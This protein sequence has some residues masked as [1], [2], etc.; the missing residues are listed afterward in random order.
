MKK[1]IF[2]LIFLVLQIAVTLYAQTLPEN[3][4]ILGTW[5]GT[6]ARNNTYDFVFNDDGTGKSGGVDIIFSISGNSITI[7]S[8]AGTSLR[9]N[10][11]VY[12]IN[13][14]RVIFFFYSAGSEW[15]V[16]LI[17]TN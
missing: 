14:Q 4:W 10:I 6:D 3:R 12:K 11:T 9:T 5:Q 1:A 15:Y 8:Q 13:D 2:C 16:N 7:F 17:K